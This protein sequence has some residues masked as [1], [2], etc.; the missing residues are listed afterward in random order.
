MRTDV[1]QLNVPRGFTGYT[2]E[3][4]DLYAE[5]SIA[6]TKTKIDRIFI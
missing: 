3:R 4:K 2:A 5:I 1:T 6:Y